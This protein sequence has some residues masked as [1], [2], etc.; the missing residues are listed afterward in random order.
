M[1]LSEKFLFDVQK[2]K[3]MHS[4]MVFVLYRWYRWK[5]KHWLKSHS[6]LT[7]KYCVFMMKTS[8]LAETGKLILQ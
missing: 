1:D 3:M 5:F 8:W 4:K 2:R 6:I 7:M